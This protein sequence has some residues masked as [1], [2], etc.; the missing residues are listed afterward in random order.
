MLHAVAR[1]NPAPALAIAGV[2]LDGVRSPSPPAGNVERAF[3][4][5]IRHAIF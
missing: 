4:D 2:S 1:H 5:V 3:D